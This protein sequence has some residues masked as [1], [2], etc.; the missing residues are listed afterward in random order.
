MTQ[1]RSKHLN[2]TNGQ[3]PQVPDFFIGLLRD[4]VKKTSS[5]LECARMIMDTLSS[6]TLKDQQDFLKIS[7]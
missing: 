6:T 5:M 2:S 7:C 1:A 3:L 4:S